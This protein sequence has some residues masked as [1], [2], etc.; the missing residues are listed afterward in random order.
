MKVG[1]TREHKPLNI[2]QTILRSTREFVVIQRFTS[3]QRNII[4]QRDN[5]D[6]QSTKQDPKNAILLIWS[7]LAFVIITGLQINSYRSMVL[8]PYSYFSLLEYVKL[9]NTSTY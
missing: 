7:Q 9:L 6:L 3:A 8:L 1:S 2:T 4:L 5:L